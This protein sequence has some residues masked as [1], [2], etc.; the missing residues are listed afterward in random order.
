MSTGEGIVILPH[1]GACP[2]AFVAAHTILRCALLND[3][4][5]YNRAI[6]LASSCTS[7][8][9]FRPKFLATK[10]CGTKYKHLRDGEADKST[11]IKKA[12]AV[13]SSG[14]FPLTE[15]QGFVLAESVAA[16]LVED[17]R[18]ASILQCFA[19]FG[20]GDAVWSPCLVKLGPD[21]SHS[22]RPPSMGPATRNCGGSR[23]NCMQ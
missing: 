7:S 13:G 18:T 23:L 2:M 1:H 4:T 22:Q 12:F 16:E 6:E 5:S 8:A 9:L 14:Q 3:R 17:G 11:W 21:A 15:Q 19:F 20:A 10:F